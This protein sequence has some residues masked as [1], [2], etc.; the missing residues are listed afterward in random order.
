MTCLICDIIGLILALAN[1]I[2]MGFLGIA[3]SMRI[4]KCTASSVYA[5]YA[6]LIVPPLVM[7]CTSVLGA[8][9]GAA[10]RAQPMLYIGF[11]SFGIVALLYLVVNELLVEAREALSGQESWWSG[12]VIFVGIYLVL[13]LDLFIKAE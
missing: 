11:I 4:R 8:F 5:R 9:V 2:E 1:C 7:L 13:I 3:V 6:A 12:M 10:A